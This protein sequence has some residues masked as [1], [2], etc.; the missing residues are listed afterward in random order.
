MSRELFWIGCVCVVISL[1]IITCSLIS[2]KQINDLTEYGY[3]LFGNQQKV[4]SML[5]GSYALLFAGSVILII[6][7]LTRQTTRP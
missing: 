3:R 7:I 6:S 1:L 2:S 4:I 5:I